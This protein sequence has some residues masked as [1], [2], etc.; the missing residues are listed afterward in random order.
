MLLS[1]MRIPGIH[2]Y[3][4]YII[5]NPNRTVLYTGMTND[6]KRRLSE[7]KENRGNPSTFAG[8]YSCYHL[9]YYEWYQYVWDAIRR[10]KRI[11]KWSRDKKE[12]LINKT[13]P[14]WVFASE[15][16]HENLLSQICGN[17]FF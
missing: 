15:S 7:H 13:N 16:K 14:E 10:E 17:S 2:N 5:T 4:V 6:L 11:K 3:Y 12:A 1:F 8:R 9:L